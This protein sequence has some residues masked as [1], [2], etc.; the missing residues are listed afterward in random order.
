M[1][2]HIPIPDA[3]RAWTNR[4]YKWASTGFWDTTRILTIFDVIPVYHYPSHFTT[5]ASRNVNSSQVLTAQ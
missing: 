2:S 5:E 1:Q 3:C 4:H